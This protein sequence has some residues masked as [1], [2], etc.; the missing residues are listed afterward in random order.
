VKRSRLLGL[1]NAVRA[2]LFDLD[3]VLTETA[4]IHAAAWKQMFDTYLR[5][6]A[7]RTGERFAPFDPDVD[8]GQYVDGKPRY[9]GVRSFLAS[10]GIDLPEGEP[11]DPTGAETI[12][13]LGKRKNEIVESIIREQGV[14]AYEGSVRYL[15]AA[16]AARFRLAVVSSS[17]NAHDVLVAAGIDGFFDAR[18]DGVVAERERL[19]GKPAPDTFL[20]GARALGVGPRSAAV[21]EDAL[22]GV[23]AGRAGRF[24][25]VVGVDRVGHAEALREHGAHAV[26]H[27]LAELLEEP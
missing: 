6:R 21:F 15:E 25:W 27:D 7:T 5:E 13:G 8:Y 11:G 17:T 4:T 10:R 18:I 19:K 14:E 24:A 26:V 1:P 23:A 12:S 9:D 22:A 2:C 16:R 3:G 20:A